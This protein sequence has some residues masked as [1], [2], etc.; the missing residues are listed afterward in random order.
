MYFIDL[1][2][3]YIYFYIFGFMNTCLFMQMPS[4]DYE[5]LESCLSD[6]ARI[7]SRAPEFRGAANEY[8]Q[9]FFLR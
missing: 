3:K 6:K 1:D 7:Q 4:P 2:R 5:R 8:D 9:F